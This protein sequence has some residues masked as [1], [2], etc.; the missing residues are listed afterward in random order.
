MRISSDIES[1]NRVY[2]DL[3]GYQVILS[4]SFKRIRQFTYVISVC[5]PFHDNICIL[6]Q[7]L[8]WGPT[9]MFIVLNQIV[10]LPWISSIYHLLVNMNF[11]IGRSS[12]I[13]LCHYWVIS[14]S[15]LPIVN[16]RLKKLQ[17]R[18]TIFFLSFSP[19][20]VSRPISFI[21]YCLLPMMP[22]LQMLKE[23]NSLSVCIKNNFHMAKAN[24]FVVDYNNFLFI[25]IVFWIHEVVLPLVMLYICIS[26]LPAHAF[27]FL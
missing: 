2:T 5:S 9:K 15:L 13:I 25:L 4:Y 16:R 7:H 14:I 26:H 21:Y 10:V 22:N 17:I 11:G 18:V 19:T 3:N 24:H 12:I 6:C 23:G 20:S 8:G 1:H 27:L